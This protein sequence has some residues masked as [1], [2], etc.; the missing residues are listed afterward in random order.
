MEEKE[1]L[2]E[3]VCACQQVCVWVCVCMCMGMG[4]CVHTS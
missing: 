1:W 2:G 3:A 4:A